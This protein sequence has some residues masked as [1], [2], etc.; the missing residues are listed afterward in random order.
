MIFVTMKEKG[1]SKYVRVDLLKCEEFESGDRI[2]I[3]QKRGRKWA[4][5]ARK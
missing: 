1:R 5:K 3:L 2:I 4:F